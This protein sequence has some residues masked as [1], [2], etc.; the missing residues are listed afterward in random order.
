MIEEGDER[1]GERE[2]ESSWGERGEEERTKEG[3]LWARWLDNSVKGERRKGKERRVKSCVEGIRK[4]ETE[5]RERQEGSRR[6]RI[7]KA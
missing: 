2:V 1:V 6:K 7:E 3:R 4:S 5:G